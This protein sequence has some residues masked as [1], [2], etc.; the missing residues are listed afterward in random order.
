MSLNLSHSC[1]PHFYILY[2]PVLLSILLTFSPPLLF[3]YQ[4]TN[5][6]SQ[7]YSLTISSVIISSCSFFIRVHYSCLFVLLQLFHYFP[8]L[9]FLL[10]AFNTVYLCSYFCDLLFHNILLHFFCSVLLDWT[11]FNLAFV[12]ASIAFWHFSLYY[13]ILFPF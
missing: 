11:N 7:F 8:H 4:F 2:L 6:F 10:W 12:F 3:F 13:S 5:T 1:C 9:I